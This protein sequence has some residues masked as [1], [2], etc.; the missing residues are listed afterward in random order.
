M[1][2]TRKTLNSLDR[3]NPMSKSQ[4]YRLRIGG[5]RI[6]YAIDEND[7]KVAKIFPRG[8]GYEWLD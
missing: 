6:V 5:Y 2:T 8:Q 4:F 7:V 3:N 1:E